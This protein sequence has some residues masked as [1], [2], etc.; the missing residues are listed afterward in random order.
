M[1]PSELK[2]NDFTYQ[3]PDERVAKYPLIERDNS[4]LLLYKQGQISE[5]TYRNLAEFLPEKSSLVFNN[6]KVIHARLMFHT[7]K[8]AKVEVFCLEPVSDTRDM[9]SAMSQTKWCRWKCLVGRA[10]QDLG[11]HRR[12]NCGAGGEDTFYIR[13]TF[14]EV[15]AYLP[16][17]QQSNTEPQRLLRSPGFFLCTS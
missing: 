10:V 9:A 11:A 3:L 12:S 6:T 1:H 14:S 7:Q 2:I 17:S 8:D 16:V 13:Y 5:N 15:P 4:K